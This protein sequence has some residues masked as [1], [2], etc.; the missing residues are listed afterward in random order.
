MNSGRLDDLVL[1]TKSYAGDFE[2]CRRLCATVDRWIDPAIRH[3]LIIDRCDRALFEPLVTARRHLVETE[4][5]LPALWQVTFRGRRFWLNIRTLPMRGW[6]QQQLA[7]IAHVS[8]LDATAAI[9]IDSDAEFIRPIRRDMI[10]QGNRVRLYRTPCAEQPETHVRWHRVSSQL[11]GLNLPDEGHFGAD[12]IAQGITWSPAVARALVDRL[13]KRSALPWYL[14]LGR[15]I[16][17]SEYV[18]YGIFAEKAE[19]AHRDLH[20]A[21]PTDLCVSIWNPED[22]AAAADEEALVARLAPHH[23]AVHLQS[24]L[25]LDEAQRQRILQKMAA[26]GP[27]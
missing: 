27:R 19:G 25:G 26:A 17:F 12:Y 16:S 21:D 14:S 9:I 8:A 10:L 22:L 5:L 1:V 23:V 11:L 4:D 13:Q 15:Q 7:K 6:I 18:L 24:N 2:S 20:I 3:D